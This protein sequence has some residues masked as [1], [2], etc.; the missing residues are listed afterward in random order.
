MWLCIEKCLTKNVAP[1]QVV[2]A[3]ICKPWKHS[4]ADRFILWRNSS[5]SSFS[6]S[7][8]SPSLDLQNL[9]YMMY[10]KF[11]IQI[12]CRFQEAVRPT[13][14]SQVSWWQA[15]WSK[16]AITVPKWEAGL[17]VRVQALMVVKDIFDISKRVVFVP[18][19]ARHRPLQFPFRSTRSGGVLSVKRFSG[20]MCRVHLWKPS[21]LLCPQSVPIRWMRLAS[22]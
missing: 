22:N 5:S 2:S 14:N 11:M 13:L 20:S 21:N 6:S 17:G 8:T 4:L 19:E 9:W 15:H 1:G 10:S 18:S 12:D 7:Q 3:N 16:F